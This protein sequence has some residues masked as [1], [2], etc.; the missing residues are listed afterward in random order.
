M[1][2]QERGEEMKEPRFLKFGRR[3]EER[4]KKLTNSL[5]SL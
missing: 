1:K 2:C 5:F 3:R 4:E